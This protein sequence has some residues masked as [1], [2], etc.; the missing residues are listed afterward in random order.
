[1]WLWRQQNHFILFRYLYHLFQ[2]V[3]LMAIQSLIFSPLHQCELWVSFTQSPCRVSILLLPGT[4]CEFKA[5][6]RHC[7]FFHLQTAT[8]TRNF[9]EVFLRLQVRRTTQWRIKLAS[10]RACL[11]LLTWRER[12]KT[13]SW[14]SG[15]TFQRTSCYFIFRHHPILPPALRSFTRLNRKENQS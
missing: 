8:A 12:R 3:W 1:M 14:K 5:C 15:N 7:F 9:K 11:V 6:A 13:N 2:E 4:L 10:T